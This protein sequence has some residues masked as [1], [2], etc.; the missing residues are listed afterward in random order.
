MKVFHFSLFLLSHNLHS[1]PF[2]SLTNVSIS[3]VKVLL[4][5]SCSTLCDPRDYSPPGSSVHGIIHARMF[6][7][8]AILFSRVSS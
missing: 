5:L 6:E 7:W 8:V 1:S 3:K 4:A 2:I